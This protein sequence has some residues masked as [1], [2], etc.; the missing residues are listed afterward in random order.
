MRINVKKTAHK[1]ISL[2]LAL[3]ML[4]GIIPLGLMEQVLRPRWASSQS[5]CR[6]KYPRRQ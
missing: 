2:M 3:V 1:V 5:A 4:I 6:R